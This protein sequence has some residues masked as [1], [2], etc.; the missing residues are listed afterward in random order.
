MSTTIKFGFPEFWE[1]FYLKFEP[2]MR[3]LPGYRHALNGIVDLAYENLDGWQRPVLNLGRL[4]GVEMTELLTLTANGCGHGAMKILRSMLET[5]IDAEFIRLNPIRFT[6]YI[7]WDG[8]ERWRVYQ[9]MISVNPA[10]ESQIGAVELDRA[11]NEYDRVRA[12][13]RANGRT[14]SRWCA[15]R[16]DVE[17]N[18]AKLSPLYEMIHPIATRLLHGGMFALLLHFD[19]QTDKHRIDVPPA[20]TWCQQALVGGTCC[21][22]QTIGTLSQALQVEP[23]PSVADLAK[24][25][26]TAWQEIARAESDQ[27]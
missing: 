27:K 22:R 26:L 2:V 13:F 25:T 5:A 21:L 4:S 6:Q 3:V 1:S 19:G 10:A 23:K 12:A 7:E 24:D 11:K 20:M 16:L 9:A 17:A 14:P 15:V 18:Q 8:F